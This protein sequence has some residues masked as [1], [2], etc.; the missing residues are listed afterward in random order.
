MNLILHRWI[1]Y[2]ISPYYISYLF[3]KCH[4]VIA[5]PLPKTNSSPL[6]TGGFPISVHLQGSPIFSD[7][8]ASFCISHPRKLHASS[9]RVK[10]WSIEKIQTKQQK[11]AAQLEKHAYN[12]GQLLQKSRGTISFFPFAELAPKSGPSVAKTLLANA[13]HMRIF[14]ISTYQ[15]C[16]RRS[17][18]NPHEVD[19]KK[20]SAREV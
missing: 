1:T 4:L 9:L 2:T 5:I 20:K 18:R 17:S 3:Q 8:P 7:A 13:E 10:G 16:P 11:I 12:L 15:V 6:K 14:R 19:H